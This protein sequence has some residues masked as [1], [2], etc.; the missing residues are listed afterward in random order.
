MSSGAELR[1][2]SQIVLGGETRESSSPPFSAL[3]GGV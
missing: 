1:V 3:S 2:Q